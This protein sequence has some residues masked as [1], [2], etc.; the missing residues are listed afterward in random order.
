MPLL[1][2]VLLLL[3]SA[4]HPL[5]DGALHHQAIAEP[6]EARETLT[7]TDQPHDHARDLRDIIARTQDHPRPVPAP[8]LDLHHVDV[9]AD[10]I[11]QVET[12]A[13]DEEVQ[14]IAVTAVMMIEAE[15]E[16]AHVVEGEG[17]KDG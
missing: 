15:A 13:E 1:I 16:V 3:A 10:G 2:G 11:V 17:A 6:T 5:R 12:A 9:A 14:A 4:A 8:G 7:L